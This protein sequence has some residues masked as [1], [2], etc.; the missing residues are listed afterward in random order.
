MDKKVLKNLSYG[1]YVVSAKD[2]RKVGCV[3]NSVVQISS[4]PV[5]LIVSVNRDNCT[6]EVIK[7]VGKFGISILEESVKPELIGNFGYKSSKEIDKFKDVDYDLVNDVPIL[8]N[9]C[10]N[11]ICKVINSVEVSTHTVFIAEVV[12]SFNYKDGSPM[13]YSYYQKVL[14]GKSPKSAPTYIEEE[15]SDKKSIWKCSICGYEVE[16][17]EL[18]SDYICP[19]CGQGVEVFKKLDS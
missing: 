11:M 1:V 18:D 13:T 8:I 17:E 19:I 9:T 10:G 3:V 6:N 7:K 16:R 15:K 2:D 12:E 14:K 5:T 4:N